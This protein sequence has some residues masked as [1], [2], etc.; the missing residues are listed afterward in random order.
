MIDG[1]LFSGMGYPNS[2]GVYLICEV[3]DLGKPIE[4][5]YIGSSKNLK[6]RLSSQLKKGQFCSFNIAVAFMECQNFSQI[7]RKLI[8][9]YQPKFNKML[10]KNA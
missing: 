1:F 2:S 3:D 5:V 10:Y 4:I 7:E 8:K 6:N 9:A